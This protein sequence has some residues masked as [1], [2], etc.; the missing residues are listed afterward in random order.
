MKRILLILSLL[1]TISG[2]SQA[3]LKMV[4]T[5]GYEFPATVPAGGTIN[6]DMIVANVDSTFSFNDTLKIYIGVIDTLGQTQVM[7]IVNK[8]QVFIGTV[9]TIIVN[10]DVNIIPSY[11]QEGNNTV[12]I[13]PACPNTITQDSAYFTT[14]ID[15]GMIDLNRNPLITVYPNPCSRFVYIH[16][17]GIMPEEV[18]INDQQGRL[19]LNQKYSGEVDISTFRNGVYY[20]QVLVGSNYKTIKL[21]KD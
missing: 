13:W 10:L 5:T 4:N 15:L 2:Y 9:D 11:F 7:D 12:V 20:L 14:N 21:I 16:S 8:G 17:Q 18:R 19:L 3:R 6:F 1:S